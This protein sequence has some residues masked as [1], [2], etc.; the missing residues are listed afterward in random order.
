[1]LQLSM[2]KFKHNGIK[3][4]LIMDLCQVLNST[5]TLTNLKFENKKQEQYSLLQM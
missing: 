5:L 4:N 1:M 3:L 2:N